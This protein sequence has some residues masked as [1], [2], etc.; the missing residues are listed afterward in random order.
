MSSSNVFVGY[1]SSCG[2]MGHSICLF[3]ILR[4]FSKLPSKNSYHLTLSPIGYEGLIPY[5][6]G[7]IR[8]Y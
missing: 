7:E 1:I 5:T 3:K 8:R 4:D 6:L 2:S